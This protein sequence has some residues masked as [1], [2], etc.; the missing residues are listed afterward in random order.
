MST[1]YT[2]PAPVVSVSRFPKTSIDVEPVVIVSF[3]V[4]SSA[5][6][7]TARAASM[8]ATRGIAT[9]FFINSLL[10]ILTPP[11]AGPAVDFILQGPWRKHK[12]NVEK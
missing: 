5:S 7:G 9:N 11:Q 4:F 3:P 8:T 10:L 12:K 6:A 1:L 2:V